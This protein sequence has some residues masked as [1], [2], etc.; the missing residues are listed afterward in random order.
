MAMSR[1]SLP[2]HGPPRH[3][4]AGGRSSTTS[5]ARPKVTRS[6]PIRSTRNAIRERRQLICEQIRRIEQAR[7]KR[8]E[9]APDTGPNAAAHLRARVAGSACSRSIGRLLDYRKQSRQKCRAR[10][11]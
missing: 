2:E 8:L 10:A 1:R 7:V 3:R 9:Q 11:T 4:H 6:L 5:W